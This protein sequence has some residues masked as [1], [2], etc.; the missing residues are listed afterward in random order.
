MTVLLAGLS[1]SLAHASRLVA[2]ART[3]QDRGSA[4]HLAGGIGFLD[5]PALVGPGEFERHALAEP[6]LGEV[7]GQAR[8]A[9]WFARA[10][11]DDRALIRRLGCRVVVFDNRRSAG[12]AARLEGVAS[13]SLTNAPLLGPH[14]GWSP[15]V[16]SFL[17]LLAPVM[18]LDPVRL[19]RSA[20]LAGRAPSDPMPLQA[21]PLPER[22]R[23]TLARLGASIP[24]ALHHLS[25]G[26]RT[27][28]CD[29]PLLHP[30]TDP[31][32][33]VEPVGPLLPTLR[34]GLPGW[35]EDLDPGRPCVLVSFGSTGQVDAQGAVVAALTSLGVQV[36]ITGSEVTSPSQ[37]LYG[38][39]WLPGAEASARADL[40]VCHG[41]SG[42][43]YQA[44]EA[45]T[46]VVCLP[47][48]LE[49]ALNGLAAAR[50]GVGVTVAARAAV[51]S[52]AELRGLLERCL[53]DTRLQ[54]RARALSGR[55]NPGATASRIATIVE[56][57]L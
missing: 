24:P 12:V 26:D 2:V 38:A 9:D 48:H 4:T 39:R 35:W 40:V 25:L 54:D 20:G 27:A 13:V 11:E 56:E 5:D 23:Q 31:P 51:G 28:V 7:I 8:G 21:G 14:L 50:Q 6:G 30:L 42:T 47:G 55:M 49:Q 41:G 57:L 16:E 10:L 32:D 53:E 52:P 15:S 17:G 1:G 46:P 18:G 44:L 22:L 45:G 37:G 3:L 33:G 19:R 34:V 36:L 43:V 29:H